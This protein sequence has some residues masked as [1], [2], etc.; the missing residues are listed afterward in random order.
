MLILDHLYMYAF[1]F[2]FSI[3][4]DMF[5]VGVFRIKEVGFTEYFPLRFCAIVKL[6][7]SK[8]ASRTNYW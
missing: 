2:N 4:L 1:F 8:R 5:L 3:L 7:Y 6:F